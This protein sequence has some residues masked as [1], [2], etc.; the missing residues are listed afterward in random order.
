MTPIYHPNINSE[1]EINIDI[2]GSDW[3][4]AN[5]MGRVLGEIESVLSNPNPDNALDQEIATI[6][7]TDK[8]SVYFFLGLFHKTSLQKNLREVF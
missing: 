8:V 1:G 6:F 5:T 4:A 2:L 7:K 3:S